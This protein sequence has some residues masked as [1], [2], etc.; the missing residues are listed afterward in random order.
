[1]RGE[2]K[3]FDA[4]HICSR[5][6]MSTRWYLKNGACLHK[7]CHRFKVHMDTLSSSILIDKLKKKR[8]KVWWNNLI[9]KSEKTKKYSIPQLRLKLIELKSILTKLKNE[10]ENNL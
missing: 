2:L 1:G 8:G 5:K 3:D 7:G 10:K 6:H 4:H 9:K